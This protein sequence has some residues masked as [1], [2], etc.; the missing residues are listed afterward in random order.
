LSITLAPH[1]ARAGID[2]ILARLDA[3][4]AAAGAQFAGVQVYLQP[5]QDLQIDTRP[6]RAQYQ[7]TLQDADDA[8]L[9][10]WAPRVLERLRALPELADVASDQEAGGLQLALVVDRDTASRLG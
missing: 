1:G 2:A 9:A 8:E 3:A 7:Y 10:T 5:V 6:S 4:L